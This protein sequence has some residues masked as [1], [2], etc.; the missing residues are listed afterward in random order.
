MKQVI[1]NVR[2]GGLSIATLPTPSIQP[3]QL[4]IANR[5]SLISAGTERSARELAKKSLIAKAKDRPDHVKRVLEKARNEG[6]WN[7]IRQ[8]REKL[9]DP[10]P[11]GYC[12][13]GVVLA[14]GRS[15]SAFKPGDLVA[16][17]GGHA[18]VVS[19][20]K[21]LCAKIPEGVDCDQATFAVLG[22]IAM[23]AVRLSK[24]TL[25]ETALV[26][27][28]GLVGQITVA[29]LKAA[30]ATV[31][32]TDLDPAKCELAKQMGA[33][34]AKVGIRADQVATLTGGLGAD[35][36]LIT[37]ST[38]SNAPIDLA[39]HAVRQKGRVVL[40]GVVGLELDRRPFYFKEAEFVV[41]CSYGPGR[42]DPKYEQG[43]QDYPAAYIRWTEQRN[44]QAV[45]DLM[46]SGRLD[47]RPL[48][49]HRFKIE[50]AG[51]AYDLIESGDTPHLGILL[52]YREVDP[53]QFS[54]TIQLKAQTN[55]GTIGVSCLG[56]G[57]FARMVLL[58]KLCG[59]KEVRP[60]V[61]C[62]AGG[63]SAMHI[64]NKLGFA[65]ATSDANTVFDSKTT[66]A[67]FILTQ[68]H[69]HAEQVCRG[70]R[71]GKH[72]FVEKPLCMDVSEL[73]AIE[74]E[75]RAAEPNPSL[76]MVGFNRRFSP[77]AKAVRKFFNDTADPLTVS[78][79][80]NAGMIPANHW[81]QDDS[82]GG[83]RIIGEAC[84]A[85]DLAVYL[86]N[87]PVVRVFAE[88]IGGPTAPQIT[89]DQCFITMRHANGSV[90]NVAYLAGGDKAFPK[91][92]IEVFGGGKVAVIDDF[93][94]AAG[95]AGG[96]H[97]KL[98]KGAQDKGHTAEL[99]AFI[100][101]IRNGTAAPI[102]WEEI[103]STTLASLLA[104]RSLRDGQPAEISSI[105]RA[106]AQVHPS[107]KMAG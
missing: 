101:A 75:L 27:G 90:S 93:R 83:G 18:E 98:W 34:E 24:V 38:K 45:L 4:L 22:A 89:D 10:M 95:W 96:R 13:A 58:P 36:V 88:A 37:A 65:T 61:I 57:N 71:S 31:I 73:S 60:D 84:H 5:F 32:G 47:V 64:G 56:A 69:Q 8:V 9:D 29:L 25:G 87:S 92:R 1:Q 12:A 42:Y 43:G 70:I 16:S 77:A 21:N 30:G 46:A 15:V 74:D 72:V 62:S 94:T 99:N 11:M 78:V 39:A 49:S 51:Q 68:H 26:V 52:E 59:V 23:Q 104:V 35:V 66:D 82:I 20:G 53:Q 91:E 54:A 17:N 86:V 41:S 85:I 40:V 55:P 106:S 81:T 19:V 105:A 44:I 107:T 28:L 63:L 14:C 76:V 2:H 79:R 7:T 33:S 80:F 103:R 50:D 102:S 48:I 6:L 97:K 100:G 67:V 3:D